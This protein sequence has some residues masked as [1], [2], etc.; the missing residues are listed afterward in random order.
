MG[1][2]P[3]PPPYS[4]PP[5]GRERS[6]QVG[7]EGHTGEFMVDVRGFQRHAWSCCGCHF[8]TL[9]LADEEDKAGPDSG[10]SLLLVAVR[11][12]RSLR[13]AKQANRHTRVA[14]RDAVVAHKQA[15][16]RAAELAAAAQDALRPVNACGTERRRRWQ[17]EKE[18]THVLW[19][20]GRTEESY[21]QALRFTDYVYIQPLRHGLHGAPRLSP[22]TMERLFAN[23]QNI[24]MIHDRYI[25][26]ALYE[27]W[28][29]LDASVVG[30]LFQ[31]P[32]ARRQLHQHLRMYAP[33][34]A[35]FARFKSTLKELRQTTEGFAAWESSIERHWSQLEAQRDLIEGWGFPHAFD[36]SLDKLIFA[37]ISRIRYYPLLLD[38]LQNECDD[39][40]GW[41]LL[42][43]RSISAV[44]AILEHM[45]STTK[46]DKQVIALS[47]LL[48]GA[49]R[50]MRTTG[51]IE[52][53]GS[54]RRLLGSDDRRRSRPATPPSRRARD[55]ANR[56][57]IGG[58]ALVEA[59]GG[60]RGLV[61]SNLSQQDVDARNA[62]LGWSL[63]EPG[64][65]WLKG[66]GSSEVFFHCFDPE[67]ASS[68]AAIAYRAKQQ[69]RRRLQQ[70]AGAA[71]PGSAGATA[72][73]SGSNNGGGGCGACLAEVVHA[74]PVPLQLLLFND[75]LVTA[76]PVAP[77]YPALE[78]M[79]HFYL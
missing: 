44:E 19:E 42:L 41:K 62:S 66:D 30:G 72:A 54:S 25:L 53:A 79:E 71:I 51:W 22:Q 45:E 36:S 74:A 73:S 39:Q 4:P 70:A 67:S 11:A 15:V 38:R 43:G 16:A 77:S 14:T 76:R 35:N 56:F 8:Q 34:Q 7:Q 5:Y 68:A 12:V 32:L 17:L 2:P 24:M 10:R 31:R 50:I 49:G 26:P 27:Q 18:R 46:Q 52:A 75:V 55:V 20:F 63:I 6:R 78:W 13:L 69:G 37:P 33:F 1:E 61:T 23:F 9:G 28:D 59:A 3:P 29:E 48:G 47:D 65:R 21:V 58:T 64:R 40:P 60:A 57:N